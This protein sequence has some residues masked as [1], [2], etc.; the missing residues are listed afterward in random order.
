MAT[1]PEP[2]ESR[3]NDPQIGFLQLIE[4]ILEDL[5][6]HVTGG[7]QSYV[8]MMGVYLRR[9][10]GV[11]WHKFRDLHRTSGRRAQQAFHYIRGHVPHLPDEYGRDPEIGRR[12]SEFY[13]TDDLRP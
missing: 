13:S 9:P 3:P 2:P 6:S 10:E 7:K 4:E 8:Q 12:A 11:P 1:R 5:C